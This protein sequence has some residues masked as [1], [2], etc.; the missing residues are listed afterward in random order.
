VTSVKP[1]WSKR[2]IATHTYANRGN[3]TVID[4]LTHR[5]KWGKTI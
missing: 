5:S 4:A 2:V 1:D 3:L